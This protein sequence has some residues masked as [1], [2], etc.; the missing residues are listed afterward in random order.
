MTLRFLK[1]SRVLIPVIFLM[2]SILPVKGEP[3]E[4]PHIVFLISED[5]LNYEAHKTIPPFADMLQEK[6]GFQTTV[7]LGY[8]RHGA[9]R[10]PQMEA[11]K[12]ADL[13]LVFCRRLALPHDQ[14]DILKDYLRSGK[15]LVGLR[16]ANHGFSVRDEV[17]DGHEGWWGFVPD[18]LGCH[19]QGYEPEE[20][21]T[22]VSIVPEKADHPV[23]NKVAISGWASKGQVYK[24][25]P[26]IDKNAVILLTGQA[27]NNS[28]PQPVA[29]TRET[30]HKSRVFYTSLGY[31]DDFNYEPF[32]QLVINGIYWALNLDPIQ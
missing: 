13:V 14:M 6:Y 24:V 15:P 17:A 32:R 3:P 12:K 25:A 18:I 11:L 7:L 16:T 23:L 1:Q 19:N 27:R 31:P 2:I 9:Y 28:Q 8:G 5:P 30:A 26:L 29:W 20:F 22:V 21:G 10:F 4:K